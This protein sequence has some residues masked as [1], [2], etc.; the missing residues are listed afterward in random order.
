MDSKKVIEK[1]LSIAEKQQKIIQKLAQTPGN[2]LP[3]Q[4]LEPSQPTLRE[5]D[6][7]LH[8][9][10]TNVRPLVARL[11]VH[12]QDVLVQFVPGKA[13]DPAFAAVQNT[14]SNLQQ[15]NVLQ[16]PSYNVKQVA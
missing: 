6:V 3:P 8:A 4:A 11:E 1:L 14:V 5:A 2:G 15:Q 10:P 7:I 9:L 12:G 13:S 16:R